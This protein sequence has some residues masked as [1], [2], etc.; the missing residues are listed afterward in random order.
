MALILPIETTFHAPEG[1]FRA[2]LARHKEEYDEE[3]K[4]KSLRLVFKVAVPW[5]SK[6]N[7]LAGKTYND[8][9]R[10]GSEFMKNLRKWLGSEYVESLA[11]E[12]FDPEAHYGRQVDLKLKHSWNKGHDNPYTVIEKVQP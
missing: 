9:L 4:L 11:G 10:D 12:A 6:T 7:V 3:G 2:S 1:N 5:M 8:Q